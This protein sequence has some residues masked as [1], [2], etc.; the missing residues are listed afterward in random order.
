MTDAR[1]YGGDYPVAT[2]MEDLTDAIFTGD[3]GSNINTYRQNLQIEY[4]NRLLAIAKGE[5]PAPQ[6]TPGGYSAPISYDSVSYTHLT[7]PTILLV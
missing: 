6:P 3:S 7:L 1:R 5:G 4:V 2:Y